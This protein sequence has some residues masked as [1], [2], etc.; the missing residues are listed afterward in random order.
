MYEFNTNEISQLNSILSDSIPDGID[1]AI[2]HRF[3]VEKVSS[4]N[5]IKRILKFLQIT[6]TTTSKTAPNGW[7]EVKDLFE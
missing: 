2:T 4:I 7:E 3:N 5:D 1:L 6:A